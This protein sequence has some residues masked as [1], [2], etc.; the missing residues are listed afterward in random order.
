MGLDTSSRGALA[1]YCGSP[2]LCHLLPALTYRR[3]QSG[4][5]KSSCL[6]HRVAN[7]AAVSAND[8]IPQVCGSK[9]RPSFSLERVFR[10]SEPLWPKKGGDGPAG[11]QSQYSYQHKCKQKGST[12]AKSAQEEAGMGFMAFLPF[13]AER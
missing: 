11:G 3:S 1:S 9:E 13:T 4:F 5:S 8:I 2:L 12:V 10:L 7:A 6:G